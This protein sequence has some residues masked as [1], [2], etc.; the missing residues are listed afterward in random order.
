MHRTIEPAITTGGDE[1]TGW[2]RQLWERG[3]ARAGNRLSIAECRELR[4]MYRDTGRFRSR[5]QMERFRFGQ[6]EYQY[7]AYP[8]PPAVARLRCELFES[9]APVARA[10]MKALGSSDSYPPTLDEFL[11]QCHS[12]GQ[13]M[14]T[15][16]LL[17]Y[18]TGDYNCL[19]QDIYGKL[20]FPFQVIIG[21]SEPGTEYQGGE[22]LVVEQRPRAQSKG[23]VIVLKQGEAVI[24]STR[25]RPAEGARG[26]YR[27]TLRHGVSEVT[28]GERF[29]L[30]IIFH[31]AE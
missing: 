28:E 20:V 5:V 2:E 1:T 25:N 29:T 30:G 10:W 9:L 12:N 23:Q 14:P 11:Q 8:L 3:Y 13:K 19:H 18:R 15:P 26:T 6:G 21:L 16:L 24:I 22:L 4:E 27:T 7:F 17:R 31:D